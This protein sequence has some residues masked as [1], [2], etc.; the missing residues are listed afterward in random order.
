MKP[1]SYP[2][3]WDKETIQEI[4]NDLDHYFLT[5]NKKLQVLTIGGVSIVLQ[6]YQE[7]ATDDIDIIPLHDSDYFIKTCKK[8]G[9]SVQAVTISSTVDFNE[10]K[11]VT[12]FQGE[13]LTLHS[14]SAGNLISLKLERFTKQ[15]PEDIYAIIRKE[16]FSYEDFLAIVKEGALN[17]VGHP[18]KYLFPAQIVVE[19]MYPDRIEEFKK[20]FK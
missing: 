18:Q 13:A 4:L 15:D 19:T 20:I 14:I 17:F 16:K 2:R 1:K 8:L 6:D 10:A 7:R 9:I 11:R 3:V 12:L 5:K